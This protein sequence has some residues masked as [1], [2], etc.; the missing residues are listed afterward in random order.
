MKEWARTQSKLDELGEIN[1]DDQTK[2]FMNVI[3]NCNYVISFIIFYFVKWLKRALL[4]GSGTVLKV[5]SYEGWLFFGTSPLWRSIFLNFLVLKNC[6]PS[7][8]IQDVPKRWVIWDLFLP[9]GLT[10][11]SD[12][13]T[14]IWSTNLWFLPVHYKAFYNM[15]AISN[16]CNSNIGHAACTIQKSYQNKHFTFSHNILYSSI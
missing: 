11:K 10:L 3:L 1:V 4:G 15:F 6:C 13:I 14:K 9:Y 7:W 12:I 8:W 5:F 16:L 2:D